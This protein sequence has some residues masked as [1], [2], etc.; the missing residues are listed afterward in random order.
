MIHTCNPVS[1]SERRRHRTG[2]TA[3]IVVLVAVGLLL[4][5]TVHAQRPE[6]VSSLKLKMQSVGK[7]QSNQE[8]ARVLVAS[9]DTIRPQK[10]FELF[11]VG[12][13][14][15]VTNEGV[16]PPDYQTLKQGVSS[17]A[18]HLGKG[19]C[20]VLKQICAC[21]ST[22]IDN[23]YGGNANDDCRFQGDPGENTCA[24]ADGCCAYF[25]QEEPVEC[26]GG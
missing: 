17:N 13:I 24:G 1:V 14:I 22:L 4:P 18:I 8:W 23:M 11:R 26:P 20:V 9:G 6:R 3:A 10:G 12:D 5:A 2:W 25:R 7:L 15:L 21:A 19:Q 16:R